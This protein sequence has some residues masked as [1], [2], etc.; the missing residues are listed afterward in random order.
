MD[1]WGAPEVSAMKLLTRQM[2]VKKLVW[3][4]K[5]RTARHYLVFNFKHKGCPF[6]L[7]LVTTLAYLLTVAVEV[8]I[9]SPESYVGLFSRGKNNTNGVYDNIKIHN[10]IIIMQIYSTV[11]QLG[12]HDIQY[13]Y[14]I[15]IFIGCTYFGQYWIFKYFKFIIF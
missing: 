10:V 8:V 14:H 3:S 1:C 6:Y 9:C 7:R 12:M 13:Q 15:I 4:Q 5:L 11:I 2:L